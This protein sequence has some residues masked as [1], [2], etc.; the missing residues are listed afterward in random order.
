MSVG[1]SNATSASLIM[2][3]DNTDHSVVG[4][5]GLGVFNAD[6]GVVLGAANSA[7]GAFAGAFSATYCFL[8]MG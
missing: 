6:T 5:A 3:P 4:M 2:A 7:A 1:D 8:K